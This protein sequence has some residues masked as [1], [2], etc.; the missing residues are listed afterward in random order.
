VCRAC[1]LHFSFKPDLVITNIVM[2]LMDGVSMVR[3]LRNRRQDLKVI[4]ISDFFEAR[5]DSLKI[6]RE[7][8]QMDC[9][10]LKKPVEFSRLLVLI[11]RNLGPQAG[12]I[13]I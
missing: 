6:A 2:P 8:K 12:R 11:Q 5:P 13:G 4:F 10:F 9:M 7:I 1:R 3:H